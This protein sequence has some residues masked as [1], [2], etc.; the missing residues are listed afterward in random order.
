[1]TS[2]RASK[3]GLVAALAA[4]SLAWGF[5]TVDPSAPRWVVV[6]VTA[7]ALLARFVL[8]GR[9]CRVPRLLGPL[10]ALGTYAG[11][12]LAWSSD[13]GQGLLALLDWL[14][15]GTVF[16]FVA[17]VERRTLIRWLPPA[18]TGIVA[19]AVALGFALPEIYGGHGNPNFAAEFLIAAAPFVVVLLVAWHRPGASLLVV[20]LAWPTLAGV[21]AYLLT[22]NDSNL[23]WLAAAAA[24]AV[25][26]G[27]LIRRRRVFMA[28]MLVLVPVNVALHFGL[29]SVRDIGC[30][31]ASR[32][33]LFINTAALW[34]D[35]PIF[36]HGLG[37]F[38]YEYPRFQEVHLQFFHEIGTLIRPITIF[39]NTPHNEFLW[40]LAD[41]GVIGLALLLAAI[42]L[43]AGRVIKKQR[44]GLDVAAAWSL[45]LLVVLSMVGFPA[46]L[47]HTALLAVIAAGVLANGTAMVTS[48]RRV[49]VIAGGAPL[50]AGLLLAAG[51]GYA[52]QIQMA[53]V[54]R[55]LAARPLAAFQANLAA[56]ELMPL[57]NRPRRQLILSLACLAKA[58]GEN[59]R[60]QPEAADRVFEISA[61]AGRHTP[62]VLIK[63]VE[64]LINSARH[65]ER[66]A[67]IES[68]MAD[69][70]GRA[71]LQ[72]S[73]WLADAWLAV[74]AADAT[75]AA[76]AVQRGRAL[77]DHAPVL[78]A[79]FERLAA[80]LDK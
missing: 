49:A 78:M 21:V 6:Y 5:G 69:L 62:A 54:E 29:V 65:V 28:A 3:L 23:K 8:Q 47:P 80:T 35:S 60:L 52:S 22:V 59:L 16:V 63:R 13:P 34:W 15:L 56:R 9:E 73:F 58:A 4:A 12:S 27:V 43:F 17:G 41:L 33:E 37:A 72:P 40:M 11:I 61:S 55:H 2:D 79:Q 75:R 42:G 38:R 77:A 14:A 36:G 51:F 30:S 46:H 68:I 71:Q 74:L 25:F 1:M 64:Y 67:E 45:L 48:R 39:V 70:R 57:A 32:T 31:L 26:A 44:D 20:G 50:A 76:Y 19:V 66:R 7:A 24:G 53:F 18:I 10:L